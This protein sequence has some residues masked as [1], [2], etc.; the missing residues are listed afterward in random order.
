MKSKLLLSTICLFVSV[1]FTECKKEGPPGKDGNANVKS[2]TL[3]FSTWTWD[4][5]NNFEYAD[6]TWGE[7]TSDIANT[8]TV[9]IY[10]DTPAGWAPLPRTI[11]PDQTYSES[12]RYTYTTGA[13]KIIV[14]DS[15]W[16]PP[17]PALGT[18][19]IKVVAIEASARMAN[20]DLNWDNYEAVKERFNLPG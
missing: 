12:Q 2:S 8:G 15:D 6:F 4:T 9:L 10:V 18:W 17:S 13:F 5:A 1:M 11:Y 19:T 3:T 7:I 14:Q 20:P 16:L